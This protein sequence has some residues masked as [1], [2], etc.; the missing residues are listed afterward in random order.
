MNLIKSEKKYW[1]LA[2]VLL[3][4]IVCIIII[5]DI[6]WYKKD[7]IIVWDAIS[8]YGYLPSIIIYK[9]PT[10]A[11]LDQPE[12]KSLRN[13]I[14]YDLDE[15]GNKYIKTASGEALLLAPF[16]LI[17]HF[18]A[19][20]FGVEQTG[21]TWIYSLGVVVAALFYGFVGAMILR[22]LLLRYFSDK[23]SA[24][25]LLLTIGVSNFSFYLITQ[26]GL[27]HVY[28]FFAI[29]AFA[30][31]V[32]L[33]YEQQSVKNSIL[34]GVLLSLVFLLRPT[35]IIVGSFF[36]LFKVNS[37]SNLKDRFIFLFRSWNK[38]FIILLA[39][40]SVLFVQL[41]YWKVATGN[42][43]VYSYGTERFFWEDPKVWEIWFSYRKGWFIYTPI[44]LLGMVGF[45]FLREYAKEW[46][47]A[48]VFYFL[49]NTYI[50]A[51]WW[52]WWYGGCFGMRPYIDSYV[53]MGFLFAAFIAWLSK[54]KYIVKI[55]LSICATL[56]SV[57]TIFMGVKYYYGSIHFDGMNK[58][59]FYRTFFEVDHNVFMWHNLT[60]IDYEAAKEGK[61]DE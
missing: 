9:D 19:P 33:W 34:L 31:V 12:Y 25:A 16:F 6:Q 48:F 54:Q 28:S 40:M 24:W 51:S 22:R 7:K 41:S 14:W 50:I 32:I 43:F 23:V 15:N 27:S 39:A 2:A 36:L 52:C 60:A 59:I 58:K 30:Y 35:N 1:S 8:Y 10:L 21:F 13:K 26:P 53:I 5:F 37:L 29:T 11:F 46:F 42:W 57:L 38:I 18:S 3:S 49:V 4:F 44:M 55:P 61:R 47:G 20:L 17:A 56:L 45:L